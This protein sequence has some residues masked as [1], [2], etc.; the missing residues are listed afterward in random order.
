MTTKCWITNHSL[1]KIN[2]CTMV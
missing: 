1:W 2:V